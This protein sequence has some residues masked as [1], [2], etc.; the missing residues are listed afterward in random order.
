MFRG[1]DHVVRS[2]RFE[3]SHHG[4]GVCWLLFF[5]TTYNSWIFV[6]TD[7]VP[8]F[9]RL[10]EYKVFNE[11]LLVRPKSSARL[12][13][14]STEDVKQPSNTLVFIWLGA[15]RLFSSRVFLFL[16]SVRNPVGARLSVNL[17]YRSLEVFCTC[18]LLA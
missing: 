1:T 13:L 3:S 11:A 15:C 8:G 18:L 6:N 16:V 7:L 10:K 5:L 4:R 14:G 12:V 17:N 2:H 9:E